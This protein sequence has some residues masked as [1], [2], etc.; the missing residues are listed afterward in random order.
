MSSLCGYCGK[1]GAWVL[2]GSSYYHA[3]CLHGPGWKPEHYG[4]RPITSLTKE[5]IRE[6]V[7][8]G[9]IDAYSIIATAIGKVIEEKLKE[10]K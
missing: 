3:E 10:K 4:L 1:P 7:R 8:G 9:I 6:A 5:E 2:E